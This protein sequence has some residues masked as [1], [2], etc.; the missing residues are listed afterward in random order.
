MIIFY[1]SRVF[2]DKNNTPLH[3]AVEMNS[4]DIFDLLL[5]KGVDIDDINSLNQNTIIIFLI[6]RIEKKS[7]KLNSRNQTPLYIAIKKN[8]RE[9]FDILLSKDADVNEHIIIYQKMKNCFELR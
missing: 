2:K 8:F 9:L 6:K 1:K 5:S 4:R 7:R 3:A